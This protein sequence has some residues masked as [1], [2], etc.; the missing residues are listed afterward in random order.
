MRPGINYATVSVANKDNLGLLRLAVVPEISSI[1]RRQA[2][3]QALHDENRSVDLIA[4]CAAGPTGDSGYLASSGVNIRSSHSGTPIDRGLPQTFY[5]PAAP[6]AGL[7]GNIR[8][9]AN[10]AWLGA[11]TTGHTTT[12]DPGS[13]L[14][15]DPTRVASYFEITLP[16]IGRKMGLLSGGRLC[17]DPFHHRCFISEHY[18]VQYELINL[19][20]VTAHA[21]YNPLRAEIHAFDL[22]RAA[23]V[24]A[25][26]APGA[27]GVAAP[28]PWS[29]LYD[30]IVDRIYQN[31]L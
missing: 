23:A 22:A 13:G 11:S 18:A 27:H 12:P 6:P 10:Y 28:Q 24:A 7:A 25:A 15:A 8:A 14:A 30:S 20:A 29:D 3:L 26:A 1:V 4:Y 21:V 5:L 17:Y 19:P 16:T 31:L 2:A 9:Q